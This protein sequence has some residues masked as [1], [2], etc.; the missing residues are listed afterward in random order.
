[1]SVRYIYLAGLGLITAAAG[2]DLGFTPALVTA[3]LGLMVY[4][5]CEALASL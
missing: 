2:I 3:G 1:V 4:A 5:F